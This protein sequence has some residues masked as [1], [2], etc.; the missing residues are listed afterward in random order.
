MA[1]THADPATVPTKD[2]ADLWGIVNLI[3][4]HGAAGIW[5]EVACL[6]I[7]A[8]AILGVA[9]AVLREKPAQDE[10]GEDADTETPLANAENDA[11]ESAKIR[12]DDAVLAGR[13]K[14][15]G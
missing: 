8:T 12:A 7:P 15:E 10:D 11:G 3:L 14:S 1:A 4:L 5:D 6:A 13:A 9:L 2:I